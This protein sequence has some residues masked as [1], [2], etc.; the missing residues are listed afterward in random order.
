MTPDE[1]RA[2]LTNPAIEVQGFRTHN[3][4][5]EEYVIVRFHYSPTDSVWEGWVPYQYRRIGLAITTADQLAQWLDTIYAACEPGAATLWV[6]RERDR[7]HR[8]HQGKAVTK[9]FFDTLLN[10]EWNCVASD[11]PRNSNWARRIQDIKE[12]GYLLATDIQ[13]FCATCGKNTTHIRLIPF[14]KG[15]VTGYEVFSPQLKRRIITLLNGVNVYED[16]IVSSS[17]LI[18]DHK[19]PEI[20]WDAHTRRENSDTM[21]DDEIRAKFQL[22]DNQRNQ[23]KRE[24]C[25]RCFQTERRGQ[26]YGIHYYYAGDE[27]WPVD[28]PKRG[29]DAE[30]GCVGCSWY[31]LQVWRGS[32]NRLLKGTQV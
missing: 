18:P 3:K 1:A 17:T 30:V 14:E 27:Q 4:A 7:W 15:A 25:R 9:A 2:A 8:E 6:Q 20:R 28:V 12:A 23:Q 11:L 10:L 31:D 21:S 29:K 26:V 16:R 24:V 5:S 13:R 22:L 32:L 19:F